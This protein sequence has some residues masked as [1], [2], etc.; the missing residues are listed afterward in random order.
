MEVNKLK[1]CR[2]T[3]VNRNRNSIVCLILR[4]ER[5]LGPSKG[6]LLIS[7]KVLAAEE[8]AI[9]NQGEQELEG[10]NQPQQSEPEEE[11]GQ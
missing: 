5:H 11:T 4:R 2:Y 3:V 1:L 6:P 9:A 10:E 7:Y 8:A